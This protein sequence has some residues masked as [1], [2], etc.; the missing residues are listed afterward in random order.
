MKELFY[1]KNGRSIYLLLDTSVVRALSFLPH[2]LLLV[3]FA[4]AIEKEKG[5]M[6]RNMLNSLLYPK[7]LFLSGFGKLNVCFLCC[8]S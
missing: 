3:S 6:L 7:L 4:A 8:F 2:S 1:F 5:H